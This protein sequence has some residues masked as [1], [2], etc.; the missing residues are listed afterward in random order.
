MSQAIR[1]RSSPTLAVGGLIV[2]LSAGGCGWQLENATPMSP[3]TNPSSAAAPTPTVSVAPSEFPSSDGP[4]GPLA[5]VPPQDGADTARTEGTL[6]ITSSCVFLVQQ[7]RPVLLVW[8][9]DRTTWSAATETI[10]FANSDGSRVSAGNGM[11]VVLGGGGD[12]NDEAGTT[13]EAWLART[14]WVARPD[15]SCPLDARWWVGALSR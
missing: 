11:R 1:H 3:S 8:P 14:T 13:T 15:P 4:W 6:R 5:V 2:A 10:A 12:S 9:A 7:G